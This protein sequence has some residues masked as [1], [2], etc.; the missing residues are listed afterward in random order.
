MFHARCGDHVRLSEGGRTATRTA[1]EF[2]FGLVFSAEPIQDDELF[3]V[4]VDK[5]AIDTVKYNES[6]IGSIEIGVTACDPSSLCFPASA[7]DLRN[8]SWI[9]SGK[10]ILK[11]GCTLDGAY[12]LNLN[13]VVEGDRIGVIRTRNGE[14]E[15]YMNGLTYGVAATGIPRRV[16]VVINVYGKVAQVSICPKAPDDLFVPV[17]P[18]ATPLRLVPT[19]R[20][21]F[22]ERTGSLVKLSCNGRSAE[23]LRPFDEFNNAVVMT[24]KPLVDDQLFEIRIDRLVGKWSGSIEV[25][26]T[27]HDPATIEFPATMTNMRTGTIMMSGCGILTNGKSSMRE[28]GEF[29]LDDLK[30]GDRIGMMRKSNADLHYFIN[31]LDQGVAASQVPS[32]IWGVVDLYG[33]TLKVTIVDRDEREEQNLI[34]R[35]N[36][37]LRE[38]VLQ[39]LNEEEADDSLTFHPNCGSHAAVINNGRTAHRPKAL[40]DFNNAVVL[41]NR[42]LKVNEVFEVKIDKMVTKWAGSIEIGVTTHLPTELEYPSTM[43]NVR[44]GTWI[45]TGNGVM[46]NGTSVI[47]DYG[48]NLDKLQ[49]GDRVGVVIREGGSLHFLVNGEDQGEAGTGLPSN[50]YA[51]IDLYGQ[52]TQATIVSHCPCCSPSTPTMFYQDIHF[53]SVHG[54]NARLTNN[55]KTALRPHAMV[56]FNDAIVITS[57]PLRPGEMFSV[58]VERIIDRWSGSIEVGVTAIKPDDLELPGTMTDLDHDTWMLSGYVIMKD[59]ELLGHGYMLDL[60]KVKTGSIVGIKRHDDTSLHYYLDGVDQGEACRGLPELVYPVIDLYGQCAQVS[61]V[62][63]PEAMVDI[64]DSTSVPQVESHVVSE[65]TV[66]PTQHLLHKWHDVC[67]KGIRI[68]ESRAS[69]LHDSPSAGL[70]FSAMPLTDG[71][72]FEVLIETWVSHWAG[73]LSFGV[74]TFAPVEPLPHSMSSVKETTWYVQGNNLISNGDVVKMNYCTS[75][76]WLRP[77]NRVGVK[78]CQD[79]SIHFY[80]DGADQGVAAFNVPK[81]LFVVMELYGSTCGVKLISK[82]GSA[83]GHG[84]APLAVLEIESPCDKATTIEEESEDKRNDEMDKSIEDGEIVSE[85]HE[86]DAMPHVFHECH[87]R[88]VQVSESRLAAKR[89]SS[90]NQGLVLMSRPLQRGM[91][92]Q[93]MIESLNPRW[94]SSLSIGITTESVISLSLPVTALGLKKDTWVISGDSVFHNGHKVKSKYGVNLDMLALGQTVG[95]LVDGNNQLHLYVNGQDQGVAASDIP[96]SATIPLVDLYGM[97]DQVCI[98]SEGLDR[99]LHSPSSEDH[100]WSDSREKGNLEVR[101]KAETLRTKLDKMNENIQCSSH[102]SPTS[103]P[104]TSFILE[105]SQKATNNDSYAKSPSVSN[106]PIA[107]APSVP[108]SPVVSPVIAVKQPVCDYLTACLRLKTSLCLPNGYFK[109]EAVCFCLACS[110]SGLAPRKSELSGWTL[111]PLQRRIDQPNTDVWHGAYLPVLLGDV[112]RTLDVGR[113]LTPSELGMGGDYKKRSGHKLED[114]ESSQLAISPVLTPFHKHPY[115]D[116]KTK[117]PLAAYA[118]LEVLVRPGSYKIASPSEWVT[119]ERNATILVS[120]LLRLEPY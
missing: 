7:T 27:T 23:R 34:T 99:S 10:A 52:A 14:L 5:K 98:L 88:N 56:E 36:T 63:N 57:R 55:G 40:D 16:F 4:S 70:A 15:Y 42:P 82:G 118:A 80:I 100:V 69:R 20:L 84:D 21:R 85:I 54:P 119:K 41:T 113:P 32:P 31:S 33:M 24:S 50:L 72:L 97:C 73:S 9:L 35:R 17:E 81:K 38:N 1:S 37:V 29:N 112:R 77:G 101:E 95:I 19:E 89:V 39:S 71:E 106:L 48:Q 116:P 107:S 49:A 102:T 115:V 65:S 13:K 91:L 64:D 51:V 90:Y 59:G 104:V 105:K 96:Q 12:P 68:V 93:V 61:I 111:L 26:V 53:H 46:R 92:F 94:V 3:E 67:G 103:L 47:D 43:T 114:A 76:D 22:H 79:S 30:I 120:L 6:W 75:F 66:L 117:E 108:I 25:G 87:G 78:R 58:V 60:D 86:I 18:E 110:P 8:G 62:S 83:V 28:Y 45:M 11:D 2:N 74:T 109:K 44:S